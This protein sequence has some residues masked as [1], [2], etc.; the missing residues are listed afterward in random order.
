MSKSYKLKDALTEEQLIALLAEELAAV[1][2]SQNARREL[3]A[4]ARKIGLDPDVTAALIELP[5]SDLFKVEP[6]KRDTG[7]ALTG[8][9][10]LIGLKAVASYIPAAQIGEVLLAEGVKMIL[11][12]IIKRIRKGKGVDYIEENNS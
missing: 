4:E 2:A 6:D 7:F 12:A 9:V 8:A 3:E 5:S 10:F 11:E 1:R